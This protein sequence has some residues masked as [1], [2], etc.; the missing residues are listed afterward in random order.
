MTSLILA[1]IV[2]GYLLATASGIL[3]AALLPLPRADAV[4]TAILASFI[5]WACVTLWLFHL[6]KPAMAWLLTLGP[7]VACYAVYRLIS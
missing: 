3:L 1:A 6:K 7:S 5:L 2:G 4:L